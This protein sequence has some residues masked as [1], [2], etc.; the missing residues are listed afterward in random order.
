MLVP[1]P[2]VEADVKVHRTKA[3]E[4]KAFVDALVLRT[5]SELTSAQE[6]LVPLVKWRKDIETKKDAVSKPLNQA[7][8][9]LRALFA[10][11]LEAVAAK[12]R[13]LRRKIGE[14][15][16]KI[17]RENEAKAK[18]A[19]AQVA[20]GKIAE[21]QQLT[22]TIVAP[23][24]VAKVVMIEKPEFEILDA[25]QVPREFCEPDMAKIR[26]WMEANVRSGVPV[27]K[28][29]VPGIVFRKTIQTRVG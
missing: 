11:A 5:P 4:A 23:P 18:E 25:N 8:R 9:E 3:E 17:Q 7:L 28:L 15:T 12:E 1:L 27:E 10:P 21:A 13:E 29:S 16:L 19:M 14:A 22:S 20:V 26:Q 2:Q 6:F 24:H